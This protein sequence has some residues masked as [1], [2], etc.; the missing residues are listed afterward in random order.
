MRQFRSL[1]PADLPMGF[2]AQIHGEEP[3]VEVEESKTRII[4]RYTFPGFYES[5]DS[6]EVEG[7]QMDFTQ[8][9][10]ASTGFL[11]ESGKPL[12]P[13]FGRYIPIPFNCD[14]KVSVR[15]GHAVKFD[16]VL[17][18]RAQYILTDFPTDEELPLEYDRDLY[19]TDQPHDCW[20]LDAKGPFPV[21]L[22][23]GQTVRVHVLS[24]LDEN[25]AETQRFALPG[26]FRSLWRIWGGDDTV[27]VQRS[28]R[29]GFWLLDLGSGKWE[30]IF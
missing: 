11:A 26:E 9:D 28:R 24:I 30:E 23:D 10:I 19:E 4:V 21:T 7:D 2:D 5:E 14:Y 8:I 15:Q 13:S 12:L 17:L 18:M 22:I 29:G 20:Q 6:R 25:L 27:L 1:A 3:L 16:D